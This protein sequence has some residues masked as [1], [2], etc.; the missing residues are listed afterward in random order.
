MSYLHLTITERIKIETYLELGLKPCQIA[1]KLGVHKSTI[2]REL[3]RCQTSYSADLAQKQYDQMAKQKGRKSCLT[4][5]LKEEIKKGLN[6]SWSPEQICGRYRLEHQPMVAFKTIYNWLYAGLI[7]LD[8]SVL[9]RKGKSRQ[10]RETR[11][12]FTIGAPISKRPKEVKSRETFGHWELDTVVSSRGQSKGC[13]ATFV[14]R[15]TRFYLAFK[16]PDRTAKSMFSAIEQLLTLLPKEAFKSFTSDRGK[17]FA[18]YPLVEKL[19]IP[20]YF[21]DAYSSWQRGSNENANGLLREYFPKKTDLAVISDKDLDK[22]LSDINH[23][24]RKCLAYR[25]AV[26]ALLNEFK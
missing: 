16:M 23:R 25:T 20:F 3:R 14:E 21:A 12:K 22:A 1:N 6:A 9:R 18:C 7:Q 4:P 10:P 2:S 8:L 19:G 24:P 17:E 11:G 13:L 5:E 26:E 15:K